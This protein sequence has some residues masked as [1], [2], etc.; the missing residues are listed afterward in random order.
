MALGDCNARSQTLNFCE[1]NIEDHHH[2]A[3]RTHSAPD[4]RRYTLPPS[5]SIPPC[6]FR[7]GQV[8]FLRATV[9]AT[10]ALGQP[11]NLVR[12]PCHGDLSLSRFLQAE[13]LHMGFPGDSTDSVAI[14]LAMGGADGIR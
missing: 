5:R 2:P 10:S 6:A 14:L 3:D 9:A 1:Y 12:C 8:G 7:R 4:D 13:A 11:V